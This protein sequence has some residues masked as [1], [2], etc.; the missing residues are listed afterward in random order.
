MIQENPLGVLPVKKLIVKY[1]IPT[2]ITLMVNYLY[3]IAD[4]LFIGQGVGVNGMAATNVAF[5]LTILAIALGL[6]IG[7]G[8]AAAIS[9]CLGRKQQ[10]E[11][12]RTLSHAYTLL[13]I[14]GILVTVLCFAFAPY[15]V[16]LFGS[17]DATYNLSM[18][19]VR[20]IC[21][22]LPFLMISS[23]LTAIIRADGNPKYT[24]KCMIAGAL[25]NIV[26]DPIFI[27]VFDMGV[28]GAGIATIIG[29][30]VAGAA[31]LMYAPRFKTVKIKKKFLLPTAY[32]TKRI[33]S[34]GVPSLFMQILNAGVQIAMNNLMTIYGAFTVYGS[35][36]ALS[37]YGMMMKIYQITHA[38]FVGL[39]SAIQ[40]INGYNFGAKKFSRV[41]ETITTAVKWAILISSIWFLIFQ[42][43]GKYIGM[44]FVPGD[45][46][47]ADCAKHLFRIYMACFFISG[48]HNV[49]ASFF[50]AIGKPKLS[51]A[52]PTVRQAV[53][54]IPLAFIL[55]NFFGFNGALIAAPISDISVFLLSIVLL[56]RELKKIDSYK[57]A[58]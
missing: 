36:T 58:E 43:F 4:Q 35:E 3:N 48:V 28:V 51:L 45:A 52:I 7:D 50:Q 6:L 12:D 55:A 39:S 44:A 20:T 1:S 19:Y 15:I 13:I 37:A 57:E 54:L 5:P 16:V 11:A 17:T 42:I 23:S 21:F 18:D 38:M 30:I 34:L 14:A 41:K 46:V 27:F 33:L 31:C 22:G 10:E 26:L 53:L 40:P 24:M 32:T 56:R 29:E 8:S 9:L 25:I 49:I 47:F 2:A